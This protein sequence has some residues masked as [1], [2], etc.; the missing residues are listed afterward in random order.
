MLSKGGLKEYYCPVCHTKH[1]R[2][3]RMYGQNS[4]ICV[5]RHWGPWRDRL[6]KPSG[7]TFVTRKNLVEASL[8]AVSSLIEEEQRKRAVWV[9]ASD[10]LT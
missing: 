8:D 4:Y 5:N 10:T 3:G 6:K 7:E 2:Q 9:I 1:I